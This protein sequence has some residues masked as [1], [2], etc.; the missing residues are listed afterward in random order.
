MSRWTITWGFPFI[1]VR[2]QTY[3]SSQIGWRII[4][5]SSG[6]PKSLNILG[7]GGQVGAIQKESI[8]SVLPS[9]GHRAVGHPSRAFFYLPG[10]SLVWGEALKCGDFSAWVKWWQR[11]GGSQGVGVVAG[12]LRGVGGGPLAELPRR[13]QP[14]A[15]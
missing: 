14:G 5:S 13:G 9:P 8:C 6:K 12:A 7:S 1:S 15:W 2:E 10:M 11:R 3:D 4:N